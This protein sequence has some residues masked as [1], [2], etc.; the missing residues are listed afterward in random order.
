[1]DLRSGL[2]D[3]SVS[4]A[5]YTTATGAAVTVTSATAGLS[6]W[7]RRGVVGAKTA[8]SVSDLALLTTAHTDGGILVIEGAEHRL[9][10]PDAATAAGVLTVSW[11]GSATGITIDGGT[12]NVIG[13]ANTA[14][15]VSHVF[16]TAQT[17]APGS[18]GGLM[19][20]G[21]NAATTFTTLT[22]TG[23]TA[24]SGG[25][26]TTT[27]AASGAVTAASLTMSGALQAA[28][29]VSTGTTTLNAL[30]VT[31]ALA[32]GAVTTASMAVTGALSVGT[33]TTLTG[34]VSAPAG[35]AANITGNLVGTVSTLTT[36]T[37]NTPQTGDCYS[38]T[39][40]QQMAREAYGV[41]GT[42]YH[43]AYNAGETMGNDAL[44][45][46]TADLT[47]GVG[48]KTEVEA[49]TAGDAV[50]LGAGTFA[51][52]DNAVAMPVGGKLTG[53]GMDVTTITSAKSSSLQ[54]CLE[55]ANNA[56]VSD[57]TIQATTTAGKP[58]GA[59]AIDSQFS[60]AVLRNVR[61]IGDM[62]GLYISNGSACSLTAYDC[63][64]E[65]MWDSVAS[66]SG[67]HVVRLH[68]CTINTLGPTATGANPSGGVNCGAGTV[69]L[70][71][72]DV[73]CQDGTAG[74]QTNGILAAVTGTIIMI[75]G[76]IRTYNAAGTDLAVRNIGSGKIVLIG[77]DYDRT[78]TSN[79]G[80]GTITDLA[81][82]VT[83]TSGRTTDINSAIIAADVA[84]LDG[85]AMR[86]TDGAYTGTPPTAA[87]IADAVLDEALAD[88]N[89]EDTVGNML[90]DLTEESG[91]VYRLTATAL[92]AAPTGTTASYTVSST[93]VG[94]APTVNITQY[95][96]QAFGPISITASV[97]Q[98]G[99]SHSFLVYDPNVPGTVLWSLTTLAGEISV[100]GSGN[101]TIT[102]VGA[103]ADPDQRT[104]T[105]GEYAYILRN[106]TD[107]TV[108]CVGALTIEPAPT[109]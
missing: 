11:G 67:A 83:D 90:N 21:S 59:A 91:G 84:G 24:L 36:Y 14:S 38:S 103:T 32:T 68:H 95:Q 27:I 28:T 50:I 86:G 17:A 65:G 42:V 98:T 88:H 71:D 82:V 1:M 43:V 107:D 35:I 12:A 49:A 76:R 57:L 58:V 31:N 92:G 77:V 20:A 8:I 37:G 87:A 63:I 66:L 34:A 81:R 6:L 74:Q 15:D 96:H 44:S 69:W 93:T 4:F 22:V 46:A 39:Q 47:A 33:T 19:I 104:A 72:C 78:K 100:G 89:T 25:V 53:A 55:L 106:T 97:A 75:G 101:L 9:D 105:A 51:L 3:Q 30:T 10:L 60:N 16:G 41:S 18:A 45:W 70:F 29:I 80:G 79:T 23:A 109:A 85:A 102:L 52:G 48:V 2:A 13:Q 64:F 5:A 7:Y 26:T 73:N 40:R 56:E 62:D 54:V 94:A 99:D 61:V 108:I